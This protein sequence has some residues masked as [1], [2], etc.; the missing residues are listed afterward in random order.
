[1]T[2]LRQEWGVFP[3]VCDAVRAFESLVIDIGGAQDSFNDE[4]LGRGSDAQSVVRRVAGDDSPDAVSVGV[5]IDSASGSVEVRDGGAVDFL[6]L[7]NI[8]GIARMSFAQCRCTGILGQ[9][10]K[11]DQVKFFFT[12]LAASVCATLTQ[13]ASLAVF[14]ERTMM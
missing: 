14:S 8:G 7:Q 4:G 12:C 3:P 6:R 2:A 9:L 13:A 1:M 11:D 10:R 5:I